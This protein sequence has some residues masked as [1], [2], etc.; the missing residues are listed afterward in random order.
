VSELFVPVVV[1]VDFD[2]S[3]ES[4]IRLSQGPDATKIDKLLRYAEVLSK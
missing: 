3:R 4:E 1:E 2:V